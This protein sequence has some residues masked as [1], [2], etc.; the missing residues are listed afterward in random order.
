MFV[1]NKGGIMTRSDDPFKEQDKNLEAIRDLAKE[2]R[3]EFPREKEV[4]RAGKKGNL[5]NE[6]TVRI[7]DS[8]WKPFVPFRF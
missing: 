7:N 4:A 8:L 3:F 5:K 1:E 6:S 2:L